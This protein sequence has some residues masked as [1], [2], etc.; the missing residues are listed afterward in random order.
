MQKSKAMGKYL[1][2]TGLQA[3]WTKIKT[4]VSTNYQPKGSYASA[5]HTH[6]YAST[7]KVGNTAY[8]ISGN[9]ISIP[10]YPNTSDCVKGVNV[11]GS[12][13]V[14]CNVVKNGDK[15]V[16]TMQNL[17]YTNC[18]HVACESDSDNG[19]EDHILQMYNLNGNNDDDFFVDILKNEGGE[20]YCG[21]EIRLKCFRRGDEA[22]GHT[23]VMCPLGI[24]IDGR[25][26]FR[27]EHSYR[28][29]TLDKLYFLNNGK[30][31]TFDVD[32]AISIGL[33][34]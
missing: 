2:L 29:L 8:N 20:Y 13:N 28:A 25:E 10:A 1:D 6:S 30:D 26:L 5:N 21:G 16:F 9:T 27:F 18:T 23:L 11:Q 22:L 34:K 12:G 15:L 14:L 17:Q 33:L 19:Q 24:E 32:K 4:W 3:F 31:Y 7:V